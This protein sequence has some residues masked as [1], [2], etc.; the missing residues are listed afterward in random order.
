V[1]T[2]VKIDPHYPGPV[3]HVGDASLVV[4]ACSHLLGS[5]KEAYRIKVKEEYRHV[6]ESY[7]SRKAETELVPL[8]TARTHR[9]QWK[10]E[11]AEIQTPF[12]TGI[13]E[14]KPN[15]AEVIEYIDWSP[16]F[17]SWGLKGTYPKILESQQYGDEAKKLY[18]DAQILLKKIVTQKLVTLKVLIGLFPARSENETIFV[19][20]PNK[21]QAFHFLRQQRP[22]EINNNVHYCLSDFVAPK[23]ENTSDYMGA[24]CV[25]AGSEIET[26]VNAAEK[27]GDDYQSIMIS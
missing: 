5:N 24:F 19:D 6:R 21:T 1:H 20:G 7:L 9:Y 4:E 12:K 2:A 16:F 26:L 11:T 8:S 3:V 17:W 14:L 25:T 27:A 15:L 13:I 10:K 22:S 23:L 18:D